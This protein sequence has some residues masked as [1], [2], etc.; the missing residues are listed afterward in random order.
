MSKEPIFLKRDSITA[1]IGI[2]ENLS[3]CSLSNIHFHEALELLYITR[4]AIKCD[5]ASAELILR[6]GDILFLN[7]NVPH[8]TADP[9]CCCKVCLQHDPG[10]CHHQHSGGLF[11]SLF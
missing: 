10:C 1:Q 8:K 6:P 11:R 3:A 2:S 5:L 9:R 4:G 7:S